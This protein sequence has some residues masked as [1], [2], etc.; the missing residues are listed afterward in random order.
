MVHKYNLNIDCSDFL[1]YEP[2]KHFYNQLVNYPQ[3]IVILMDMAVN[4]L[5]N[6]IMSTSDILQST[7]TSEQGAGGGIL[8]TFQVRPFHLKKS[9]KMRE[10]DPID[11]DTLISIKGMI[12]RCSSVIPDLTTGYFRC[13]NCKQGKEEAIDRGRIN[14]PIECSNCKAKV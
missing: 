7:N 9:H 13:I 2:T 8:P 6:E 11:I 3:D 4:Q 14:E 1:D 12:I 10:L 5:Y